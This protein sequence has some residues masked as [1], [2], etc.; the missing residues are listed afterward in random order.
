METTSSTLINASSAFDD[1]HPENVS[2][3]WYVSDECIGCDL[4]ED[5]T[6]NVFKPASDGSQ[7]IV[8]HQPDNEEDLELTQES[9]EECPV[10]AILERESKH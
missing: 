5:I 3:N 8:H 10:D 7:N 1:I 2:G 6:P 4:C 9:A